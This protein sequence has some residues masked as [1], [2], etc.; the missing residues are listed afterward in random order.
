MSNACMRVKA[1]AMRQ[2]ARANGLQLLICST[3]LLLT[4]PPVA[5]AH[6]KLLRPVRWS[7]AQLNMGVPHA[8]M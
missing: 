2:A 8:S 1:G 3:R 5:G 7:R 6:R 4:R